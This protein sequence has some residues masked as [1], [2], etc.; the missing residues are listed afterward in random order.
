MD[1]TE[2]LCGVWKLGTGLKR[3][4]P[5]GSL[6]MQDADVLDPRG[7]T[8]LLTRLVPAVSPSPTGSSPVNLHPVTASCY[9]STFRHAACVI[10][11]GRLLVT[12]PVF[13]IT[14]R[15]QSS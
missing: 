8:N 1:R 9:S 10:H 15:A 2:D 11:L 4:A 7:H 12:Q 14:E 5:K 6:V 3:F 13:P